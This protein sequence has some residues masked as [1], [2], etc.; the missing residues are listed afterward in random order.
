[1][2]NLCILKKELEHIK[3]YMR[4][5]RIYDSE[6]I[7]SECKNTMFKY[8]V[9]MNNGNHFILSEDS[10]IFPDIDFDCIQYIQ[11]ECIGYEINGSERFFD[12]ECGEYTDD[13][14]FG[15][16]YDIL[17]KFDHTVKIRTYDN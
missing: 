9:V 14:M 10:Y 12:S 7:F 13:S 11:R 17:D 5:G 15:H 6:S 4:S 3:N 8:Y 16:F 1:M 2:T